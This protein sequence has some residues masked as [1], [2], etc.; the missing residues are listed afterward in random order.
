MQDGEAGGITQQIGATNVP[1]DTIR[2][3]TKMCKDV[4]HLIY[5]KVF[6][7]KT[8]HVPIITDIGKGYCR[9]CTHYGESPSTGKLT[10]YT[11][12]SFYFSCASSHV[13]CL[14]KFCWLVV[15]MMRL[16]TVPFLRELEKEIEK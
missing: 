16:G 1:Q 12:V 7:G 10:A 3:Q 15:Q 6:N 13:E 9:L 4:S 5:S 14:S 11:P 8:S 2:E